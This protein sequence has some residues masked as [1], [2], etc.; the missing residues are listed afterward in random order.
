MAKQTPRPQVEESEQLS[1]SYISI[2]LGLL[3]VVVVGILLYNYFFTQKGSGEPTVSPTAETTE[4]ATMSARPGST[5]V[6]VDGDTLWKI[7]EKSYGTGYNW[8]DIMKA[9]SLANADDIKT[10]QELKIPEVSPMI[11]AGSPAA[12]ASPVASATP[13]ASAVAVASPIASPTPVASTQPAASPAV[14]PSPAATVTGN[15]YTIAA[16]DSLW[17]IA[18]RAY[19]DPYKWSQIAEANKLVNPDV[20]HPGNVLT[21]PR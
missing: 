2:G 10:G 5:Y 13:I 7:S 11:V 12:S 9:N 19:G 15:S 8:E 3:V 14:S 17:T 1:E 16:G 4:E 6:V 21:L 18:Q 20:I